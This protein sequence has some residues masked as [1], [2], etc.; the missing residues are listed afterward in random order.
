MS[1][2]GPAA[3]LVLEAGVVYEELPRKRTRG[4][5]LRATTACA[6]GPS[7]TDYFFD[8]AFQ[9]LHHQTTDLSCI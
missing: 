4:Q 5:L 8:F 2:L 9:T 3:V 6:E 7:T 1:W